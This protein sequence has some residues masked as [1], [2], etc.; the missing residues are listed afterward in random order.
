METFESLA[1]VNV[2]DALRAA[3][4]EGFH[5][6]EAGDTITT[7]ATFVRHHSPNVAD[8]NLILDM[9]RAYCNGYRRN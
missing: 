9:Y 2:A 3:Y 7:K 6:R 5:D 8:H 4:N 1:V